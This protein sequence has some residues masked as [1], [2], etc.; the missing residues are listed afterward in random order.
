MSVDRLVIIAATS[1]PV[2]TAS[3]PDDRERHA[4]AA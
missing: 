4:D 3:R 1:D 2:M